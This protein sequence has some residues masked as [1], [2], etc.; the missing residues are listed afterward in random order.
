M[1]F[2]QYPEHMA[3]YNFAINDP[4]LNKAT[5]KLLH[6]YIQRVRKEHDIYYYGLASAAIMILRQR[7]ENGSVEKHG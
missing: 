7:K 2:T 4:F 1:T 5:D 6:Y 3:G